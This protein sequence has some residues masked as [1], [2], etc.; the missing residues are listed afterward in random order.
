[1]RVFVTGGAGYIG[2]AVT[3]RLIESGH[4]AVVFD[5]LQTGNRA[6]VHPEAKFIEGDLLDSDSLQKAVAE[7]Q[8]EAVIHL[9]AEALIDESI[10]NPGRFFSVNVTGGLNLLEAMRSCNIDKI[11]F[12]STAAVY[13]EP[14]QI[15]ITEDD[16]HEPVNAYG[17]SK[18][19]FERIM[20][21]YRRSFGLNHIS[22]RYF[23]ACGATEKF[24]ESREKETHIIP[25]LFEVALGH[26]TGFTLFGTDYDT[27]DGTCIR[28]YVHVYD[29]ANA[30]V[31]ALNQIERIG[32]GA[33]NLG[34]GK[35]D[36][37]LQ[38]IEAVRKV[39]G[40]EVPFKNG[41]RRPGDP[42]RLVASNEKAIRELG[43]SPRYTDLHSMV[44]SAWKWQMQH[45]GGYR[46]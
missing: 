34:S 38:V 45:P 39:T 22:F 16:P 35:G 2:S 21:W 32:A 18:L 12:S 43:W 40:K 44:E 8:A 23:N 28:D 24:G 33:Y 5:N 29:I 9:A 42:A 19:Q 15:P 17:E 30:H 4:Q 11:V 46:A 20:A 41:D 7:S 27:P 13:G 31:Q 36:S 37:N 26:R 25:L 1:M 6:A 3:E 14:K 10:R